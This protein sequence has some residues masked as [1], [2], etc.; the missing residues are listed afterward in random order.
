MYKYY[1]VFVLLSLFTTGK[2]F[3]DA[4]EITALK[5]SSSPS[6]EV[7]TGHLFRNA[8]SNIEDLYRETEEIKKQ[9]G[10]SPAVDLDRPQEYGKKQHIGYLYNMKLKRVLGFKKNNIGYDPVLG[11]GKSYEKAM[12]FIYHIKSE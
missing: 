1:R 2:V 7:S 8:L 3:L 12:L 6:N 5:H 4:K 11:F 9:L 10:F